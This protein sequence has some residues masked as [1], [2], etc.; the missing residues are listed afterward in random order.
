[1]NIAYP[2]GEADDEDDMEASPTAKRI[3]KFA[4]G[5]YAG[6]LEFIGKNPGILVEKETDG[7]LVEAFNAQSN[8]TSKNDEDYA[9]QCVMVQALT[10]AVEI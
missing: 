6:S 7:L 2:P 1:M 9:R 5:D 3:A 10:Q 8:A 4:F